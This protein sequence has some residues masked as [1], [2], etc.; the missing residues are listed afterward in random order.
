MNILIACEE[1]QRVCVEFRKLGHNAF[2]C[3]IMDCSGGHPEW[4]IK[5]DVIGLLNG[6]CSFNTMDGERHSIVDEWDMIIAF[7]P[8]THLAISGARWFEEKRKSGVQRHAVDFFHSIWNAKCDRIC[9]EN[10]VGIISGHYVENHFLVPRLP[11][12]QVIQPYEYGSPVSKK[13]CLWLKGLPKL[14]PTNIVKPE[15]TQ[16]AGHN[17]SGPAL[18]ARDENGKILKWN[19]PRTAIIRSKTYP[20]VAK[21]MADQW[22]R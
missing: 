18:Y 17:F 2:S 19:D 14:E 15:L 6:D 13:T 11:Y 10:P 5:S 7:P 21:A 12:T 16:S 1:S 3:D 22:G 8:C 20:G 9:V 4:H